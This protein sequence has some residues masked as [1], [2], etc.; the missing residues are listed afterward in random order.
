MFLQYAFAEVNVEANVNE[1]AGIRHRYK[2]QHFFQRQP[3]QVY[4]QQIFRVKA[5]YPALRKINIPG[6]KNGSVQKNGRKQGR[7]GFIK[8]Y[9]FI[10]G[11]NE[12]EKYGK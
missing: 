9:P 1:N 3:E 12:R 8:G 6:N 2:K 5:P 11:K 7:P 4:S 10:E